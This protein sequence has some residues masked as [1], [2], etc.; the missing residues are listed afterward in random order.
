[1]GS[2]KA[3]LVNYDLF[4]NQGIPPLI[5]SIAG[6]MLTDA[7]YQDLLA[8]LKKAKGARNFHKLL[9]LEAESSGGS[10]D[11][12]DA[13]PKLDVKNLTEFR[14]EDAMFLQYLERCDTEVQKLGFRLPGMFLGISDDTNFATAFIVRNTAEEQIFQPE[15]DRFDEIINK[16]LVRD[17][18]EYNT[19]LRFRSNGPALQSVEDLPQV[20]SIL[21]SS[22]AL[23][24]NGL[25]SFVNEQFGLKIALYEGSGQEWADEPISKNFMTEPPKDS[26]TDDDMPI[27]Q[28]I[29]K[30]QK[31]YDALKEIE[32][33]AKKFSSPQKACDCA[34]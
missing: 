7:S 12:K 29:Q 19:E 30:N 20:I 34:A 31:I 27:T 16:T 9:V 21:V 3:N 1:M 6:G 33:V 15:R 2:W 5:I 28:E 23:T 4:D 18:L 8:M 24:V 11:G 25:I 32:Q 10:V 26:G 14:K 13:I 22:G 17:L